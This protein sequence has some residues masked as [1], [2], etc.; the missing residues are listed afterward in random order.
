MGKMFNF[1]ALALLV[2]CVVWAWIS[3][4][5]YSERK[6]LEEARAAAFMAETASA[7][8]KNHPP[9]DKA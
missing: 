8:R 3:V 1:A 6:R 5:R 2:A 9:K 7:L 4:R